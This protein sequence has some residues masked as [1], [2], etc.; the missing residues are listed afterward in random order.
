MLLDDGPA[1]AGFTDFHL[2]HNCLPDLAWQDIEIATT[3]ANIPLSQPVIINAI[4]GGAADVIQVNRELAE[5]AHLTG[6]AMAVGSQ[7]SAIENPAAV[8][9]YKIVRKL[10]PDGVILANLGAHASPQAA[11]CAV[12]MINAQAIQIHLNTGQEIIMSEGDRNFSGYLSRIEAIVKK[13]TVPVIVKEV[14]CG[15]ALEQARALAN[16]GVTIIDVG[17]KGG[18]NFL[19]IEAARSQLTLDE[20]MLAWGIPTAISAVEVIS[21]LGENIHVIISGGVRTPLDATK[22]LCIGGRAVAIAGPILKVLKTKGIEGVVRWY[23]DF[24]VDLKRYMLLVGARS[25]SDLRS[26]PL[27]ITGFSREWLSARGINTTQFAERKK[28]GKSMA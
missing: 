8:E 28:N 23:Q 19:A 10:N 7:Y 21:T 18:T 13:V 25:I 20:E 5:F 15:I 14:G 1:A 11:V 17:G 26:V 4:T 6:T 16:I 22:A 12:D 2:V 3:I 24:I 9:S 27:V